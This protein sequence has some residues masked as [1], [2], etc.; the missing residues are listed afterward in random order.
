MH[1]CIYLTQRHCFLQVHSNDKVPLYLDGT[2]GRVSHDTG[3]D[4]MQYM[5]KI[6]QICLKFSIVQCKSDKKDIFILF[7]SRPLWYETH[8]HPS[9]I[10]AVT[11][12]D[13]LTFLKSVFSN[14]SVY[15]WRCNIYVNSRSWNVYSGSWNICLFWK[16]IDFFP[17]S[18]PLE[19]R[20]RATEWP[21]L[22][23]GDLIY[24]S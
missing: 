2:Y 1:T 15:S 10:W 13:F 17:F 8:T 3:H 9:Q 7:C 20:G 18:A 6:I 14:L 4:T 22:L 12:G 11:Q 5:A 23:E 16:L 19:P 24:N 21:P